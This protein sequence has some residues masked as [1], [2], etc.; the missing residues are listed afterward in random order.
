MTKP[1]AKTQE[2]S[3]PQIKIKYSATAPAIS[4]GDLATLLEI[5]LLLL[6]NKKLFRKRLGNAITDAFQQ[7]MAQGKR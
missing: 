7:G 1:Q 3:L 4:I 5:D 6:N 2:A